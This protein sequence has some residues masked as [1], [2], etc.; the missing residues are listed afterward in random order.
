MRFKVN[1]GLHGAWIR[2]SSLERDHGFHIE[3]HHLPVQV[4]Q[5]PVIWTHTYTQW[6]GVIHDWHA[7]KD[8]WDC[9]ELSLAPLHHNTD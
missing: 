5:T 9:N 7:E 2:S 8:K 3:T 4:L 1:T 6:L